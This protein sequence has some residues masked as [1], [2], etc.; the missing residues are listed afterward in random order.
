M[1]ESQSAQDDLEL[2]CSSETE[3]RSSGGK[4]ELGWKGI[5][6]PSALLEDIQIYLATDATGSTSL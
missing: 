2:Q 4:R 6:A 3:R 1:T 5:Q